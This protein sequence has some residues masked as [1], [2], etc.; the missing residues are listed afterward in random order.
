M[1]VCVI[2][3][4]CVVVYLMRLVVL[5]LVVVVDCGLKCDE[6]VVGWVCCM[7]GCVCEV[8]NGRFSG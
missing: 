4:W 5:Y 7:G 1:C 6:F 8:C 2:R 3:I